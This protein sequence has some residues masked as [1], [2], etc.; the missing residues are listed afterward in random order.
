MRNPTFLKIFE[1][2]Q[3]IEHYP[4]QVPV[5]VGS[6]LL[7]TLSLLLLLH[8]GLIVEVIERYSHLNWL[9]FF[10][11]NFNQIF[12][13]FLE[14]GLRFKIEE[15]VSKLFRLYFCL[16]I[17]IEVLVDSVHVALH[18]Y[19]SFL[20]TTSVNI[21]F[22]KKVNHSFRGGTYISSSSARVSL[23]LLSSSLVL[24]SAN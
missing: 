20:V 7:P 5:V 2:H 22:K 9:H 11:D 12:C 23:N 14:D 16:Q 19:T 21:C 8:L 18:H 10:G 4:L 13:V 24:K 17:C 1:L 15:R 6:D 3:L